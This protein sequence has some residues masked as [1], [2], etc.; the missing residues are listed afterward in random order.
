MISINDLISLT[1]WNLNH[2]LI[3]YF[4]FH[5]EFASEIWCKIAVFMQYFSLE[6]SAWLLVLLTLDRYLYIRNRVKNPNSIREKG[7][8][9]AITF[10]AIVGLIIF[11]L[12]S[13]LLIL[14][15]YTVV[16][17][18]TK[19]VMCY[20]SKYLTEDYIVIWHRVNYF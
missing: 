19:Q 5:P 12:N 8:K 15:G 11:I 20:R 7:L 17:N 6:Y 3:V 13:N 4:Q 2:F 14:N 9:K 16:G 18:N 1:V 10:C